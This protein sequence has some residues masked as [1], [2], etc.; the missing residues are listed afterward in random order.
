[1]INRFILTESLLDSFPYAIDP[2]TGDSAYDKN[3]RL[4]R[5]EDIIQIVFG[6][7]ILDDKVTLGS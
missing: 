7:H 1:M 6:H 5:I 4:K 2:T 3:G